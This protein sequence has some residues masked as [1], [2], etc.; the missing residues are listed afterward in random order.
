METAIGMTGMDSGYIYTVDAESFETHIAIS[1]GYSRKFA[2][3]LSHA[4]PDPV[5]ASVV[6]EGKP[7]YY[8]ALS[9]GI[10][11]NGCIA[12]EGLTAAAVIPVCYEDRNIACIIVSSHTLEEFPVES[13]LFLEMLAVQVASTFSRLGAEEALRRSEERFKS[14]IE[15]TS[16]IFF[17]H[18]TENRMTYMSPQAEALLGPFSGMKGTKWTALLTDSPLNEVALRLTEEALRTGR[19][20]EKY[21]MEVCRGNGGRAWLEIDE[22]P[23][24]DRNGGI[25]GM[26]GIAR[27]VTEHIRAE[28]ELEA[29]QRRLRALTGRLQSAREEERA[30]I[31]RELHDVVGQ[32]LTGLRFD[33]EWLR[34]HVPE[35]MPAEDKWK[36]KVDNMLGVLEETIQIT[37]R[38]STELRPPE[39]EYF[40]IVNAMESQIHEWRDRTGIKCAFVCDVEG[41]IDLSPEGAIALYRVL[42]ESL[43]NVARHAFASRVKIRLK[44]EG[45]GLTLE[46]ND[47]GRG[48]EKNEIDDVRSLGILGMKERIDLLGGEFAIMGRE[49]KGTKV[50]VKLPMT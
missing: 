12:R 24:K 14:I 21:L 35:D 29:H 23:L 32:A 46:I 26:V 7:A 44:Q 3:I 50:V 39:L 16:E 28:K 38:L 17:T 40:G 31:A 15:H 10:L 5:Y 25:A 20:Q 47:N 37:R 4:H 43:T 45:D 49:G 42:Q 2:N 9:P 41:E 36:L 19:K 48:I 34:S 11:A 30:V 1:R 6:E 8:S 33:L 22:S 27:D 18:D 13:R